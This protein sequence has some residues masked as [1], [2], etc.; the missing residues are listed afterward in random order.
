[1]RDAMTEA[2]FVEK[3]AVYIL[4]VYRDEFVTDLKE[5]LDEVS[6]Q[7]EVNVDLSEV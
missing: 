2:A 5:L 1:M 3:W 6:W 4:A 7:A